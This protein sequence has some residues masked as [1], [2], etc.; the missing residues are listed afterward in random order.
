LYVQ[1]CLESLFARGETTQDLMVN[2]FKGYNKASDKTFRDYISKKEDLY[3]EGGPITTD[4]LMTYAL[5]KFQT[6]TDKGVWNEPDAADEKLVA[7]Q[8][9][10][11]RL[12]KRGAPPASSKKPVREKSKGDY[13]SR[14]PVKK[15]AVKDKPAWM[16]AAPTRSEPHVKTVNGKEYCWCPKHSAWGRHKPQDCEGKGVLF[17]DLKKPP[18]GSTEGG[19]GSKSLSLANALAAVVQ[20]TTAEDE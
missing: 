17:K 12:K 8:A 14:A 9:E 6:L 3:E 18:A 13:S 2:L 7:L 5:T 1:M 10:V 19:Q 15:V 4:A 16:T 11:S 20:A